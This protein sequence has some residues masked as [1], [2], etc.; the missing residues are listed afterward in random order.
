MTRRP[1]IHPAFL[2]VVVAAAA[3][4]CSSADT[5]ST[6]GT[7]DIGRCPAE[8]VDIV[9]TVDQWGGIV[10]DLAGD[11]GEVT[12]IIS[13]VAAD[14]HDYEPT[15][16]DNAAFGSA[17][18]VVMNGVDYDH[19]ATDAI[20]A[21]SSEPPVVDGGEVVGVDE[22]ANPHLWYSPTFVYEIADA[23]TAE[24]QTIAP[25]AAL[26][27]AEQ[28][29]SW[30]TA[31]APY[32]QA[33]AS[34]RNAH[35][36]ATY[37]ATEPVFAYMAEAVGLVDRTPTGY[38]IA[39]AQESEPAPGDLHD[40]ET[41]LERGDVDVVIYNTQT[42]G[43]LTEQLRE[44]ADRSGIPV[45]EVTESLPPGATSFVVWQVGQLDALTDALAS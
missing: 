10:E 19:W 6:S 12:T 7:A 29:T 8:A 17:D 23:V 36:G 5:T 38:A 28:S 34:I 4:G 35:T 24:L 43:S 45:V 15:P 9:V 40:V 37:A 39:S 13:G 30:R 14:P 27:F 2:V 22:G 25:D 26:Y 33:I 41:V 32:D 31:M 44:R 3:V 1:G 42:E 16:G 18:L 20:D 21:L 11:C